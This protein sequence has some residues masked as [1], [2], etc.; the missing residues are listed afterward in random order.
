[1]IY[2]EAATGTSVLVTTHYMDEA[3]YC[4]RITIMVAG[5]IAAAGTPAEVERELGVSSMEEA[6][7]RLARGAGDRT[8]FAPAGT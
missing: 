3:A 5:R 2:Q 1:M 7:V 6:F 4:D 8:P